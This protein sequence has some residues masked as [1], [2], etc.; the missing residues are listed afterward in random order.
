[1]RSIKSI[2]YTNT[3]E[4]KNLIATNALLFSNKEK[5]IKVAEKGIGFNINKKVHTNQNYFE[6][7]STAFSNFNNENKFEKN[8]IKIIENYFGR[9]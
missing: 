9:N 5:S 8:T 3:K 4:N 2:N 6:Q 1:M 7:W